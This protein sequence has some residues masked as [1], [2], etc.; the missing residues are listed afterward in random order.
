MMIV[1]EDLMMLYGFFDGEICDL[2]LML[3]LVFGVGFWLVMVVLVVYDVL[4]LW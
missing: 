1:C 3:L 4:V 2:F